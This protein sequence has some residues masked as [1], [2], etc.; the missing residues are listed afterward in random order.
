[1]KK[2]KFKE[3]KGR[4]KEG[5][6]EKKKQQETNEGQETRAAWKRVVVCG[7]P[8]EGRER[9]KKNKKL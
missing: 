3:Y 2:P 5:G 8:E 6:H 7:Y 4:E 9:E 1:M